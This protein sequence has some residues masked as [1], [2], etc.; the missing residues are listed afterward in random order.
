MVRN[1]FRLDERSIA[2]LMTPSADIVYL[3][4][5]QPLEVNLQRVVESSHSRFPVCAGGLHEMRGT[6]S[7]KAIL[8]QTLRGDRPDLA[9]SLQPGI[10]LPETLTGLELLEH[11]RASPEQMAMVIDEYG[12]I[13]GLVTLHDVLEALTGE[14]PEYNVEEAMAIQRADGSW[15]LDGF[16][17]IPELKDRLDLHTVPDEAAGEYHTLSGMMMW[18]LSRLPRTGDVIEWEGWRLEVVDMDGNRIDKVLA[19]RLPQ[20]ETPGEQASS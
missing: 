12:D 17:P 10:F 3:D 11:F 2:S 18:V 13:Q 5:N 1:V 9:A 6:I 15:L 14:L 19:S 16:I 4:L 20:Q 8:A 7:A